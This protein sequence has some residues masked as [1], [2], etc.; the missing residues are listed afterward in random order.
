MPFRDI[1]AWL[2]SGR[3]ER[4]SSRL[5][6]RV[7][8]TWAIRTS[9]TI[10]LSHPRFNPRSR[11]NSLFQRHA[12]FLSCALPHASL[13]CFLGRPGLTG[14]LATLARYR[15]ALLGRHRLKPGPPDAN[16]TI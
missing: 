8:L 5:I 10:R 16:D 15:N 13:G 11:G 3:R 12:F 6:A 7:G 14:C 1:P 4:K 9:A 2:K